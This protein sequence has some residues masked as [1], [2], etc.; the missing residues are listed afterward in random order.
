[1]ATL[2]VFGRGG[3]TETRLVDIVVSVGDGGL[4]VSSPIACNTASTPTIGVQ[5]SVPPSSTTR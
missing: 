2:G 1:M 5:V 3:V 4:T